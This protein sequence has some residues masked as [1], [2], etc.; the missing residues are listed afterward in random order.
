MRRVAS[1]IWLAC[2]VTFVLGQS[3]MA[4]EKSTPKYSWQTPHAKV[5]PNGELEWAPKE[6]VFEKGPSIRYIDF[7]A[8]DDSRDGQT[9]QTAWK[10]HP[11]DS[12]ATGNAKSCTGIQT[13]VFKGGVVYRGS[14]TAAESGQKDNP[15]RL[16]KDPS[17]GAG[18][19]VFSGSTT[20][21]G[22]WKKADA[23]SAP[24]IPQPERVWYND[25]GADYDPDKGQASFTAIWQVKGQAD[26]AQRLHL[27]RTPNYDL[28]DPHMPMKNWPKWARIDPKS[29]T[30]SSPAIKELSGTDPAALKEVVIWATI[31][32]LMGSAY[33]RSM[34]DA[35]WDLAAG[36][37]ATKSLGDAN[38]WNQHRDWNY[39]YIE[40][41]AALLDAP[42]EFF[43]VRSG[44]HAGRLYLRPVGDVDPNTQ[45]YEVAQRKQF[46]GITDQSNIV[47]SG[48]EF[49]YNDGDDG[50]SRDFTRHNTCAS[51]C[52]LLT[53]SCSN[54]VIKNNAFY[55]I[56]DAIEARL[57]KVPGVGGSKGAL[58]D[59]IIVADND[60]RN[61]SGAGV[62]SIMGAH[63][64]SIFP[65]ST[66]YGYL[67]HVE[68]MRNRLVNTGFRGSRVTWDSLP[69]IAVSYPETCEIAG[70]IIDTSM[71]I[72]IITYG[73]KAS[74][75][76]ERT[77]P[78]VRY[79]IHHNQIVN[80]MLGA[81]DYGGLE[82]FQGGPTYIYDNVSRN[83]VGNRSFWGH[84]LGYNLYL[85]GGFKCYSFNNILSGG[86][87]D[88]P[89]AY[90]H[91][92]YFMVF[93]FLNQFFNN[94]LYRFALGMDGSSG[95]RSNI[96]GNL[97]SDCEEAFIRQ[98][99][100]G[101]F[102]MLGGGDTGEMGRVGI[103]TMAYASNV[104]FGNPKE[105]GQVAGTRNA[106]QR[107]APVAKGKTIEDLQKALEEQK[108][109]LAGLGWKTDKQ[110]LARPEAKDFRPKSDAD[111]KGRGVRYFVPWALARTVGE[112]NFYR[113]PSTPEVVL[114]EN[115][116]MTDEYMDRSRYYYLPRHD[117]TVSKGVTAD[118]YVTGPLESWI[119]GALSFDGTRTASL[120]HAEMT[121]DIEYP[122]IGKSEAVVYPGAKRETVDM[123]TNNFLIEL[124]FQTEAGHTGGTLVSKANDASGYK[125]QIAADG[126]AQLTLQT[127]S[128]KETFTSKSK[129]NDGKWHHLLVEVDRAAAKVTFYHDDSTADSSAIRS[130]GNDASLS[131]TGDFVVGSGFK[132]GVDFL[133]VCRSTLAES[134]TTIEELREW[135]FN[136]PHLRDFVG[137]ETKDDKARDC[138]ALQSAR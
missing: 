56:A 31:P 80:S 123:A 68:V 72:G 14:L 113:H 44:P 22:G 122:K 109:R 51:H 91:C 69:A 28:S 87:P 124:F 18:N 118:Q 73:G 63:G 116:Y 47:I 115:F 86:R 43:Y 100:A 53:G 48:L 110:P 88:Q 75:H 135:E 129:I 6:F 49:R 85:D 2:C 64:H 10:H 16:T 46:I 117:L 35:K 101:D 17:W 52:I 71:G 1:A 138:G 105:F 111:L 99:R 36:S 136:G 38:A 128:G 61:A 5:L 79:L 59:N 137:R 132:G 12:E 98:N 34:A 62:I 125:L 11:W 106:G 134:K 15:I 29:S 7:E 54:I 4:E 58:M 65:K 97:I 81:N 37:V 133:R 60:V 33:P 25:L 127:S 50:Q 45:K 78:L 9:K 93:G 112:W 83:A 67:R 24:G 95:N 82:H 77:V 19:P 21:T 107:D 57:H 66:E 102:S 90:G 23:Q 27:A 40:N 30:F 126:A 3:A 41:A 74:G 94:T 55:D 13:Y 120:S 70:N 103:P 89:E 121:K 8:G 42:G 114:G 108:C 104:F 20:I 96:L 92:G 39:F 84:Q 119:P 76:T 26:T 32:S 130:I 131:N